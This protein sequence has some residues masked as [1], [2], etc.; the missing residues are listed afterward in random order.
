MG[1]ASAALTLAVL[2]AAAPAHAESCTGTSSGG[3]RFA[4]CFDLGNRLSLTAATDGFGG[5]IAVRH[6]ITFEDD[7]DLVWKMSH[8]FFDASYSPFGDR[9]YGTLYRGTF[10]RHSRDG[11]IVL[12]LGASLQKVFLPFDVG[13]LF[14][15]GRVE[16]HTP[17]QARLGIVETAALIDLARSRDSKRFVAFGPVASWDAELTRMPLAISDH[18]VA[19]F[20]SLLGEIH[21][22]G[23]T[24]RTAADLRGEL[25]M[26]WHSTRG[27]VPSGRAVAWLERV[28]LAVNDRPIALYAQFRY[29]SAASEA[30]AG[31]G[32]RIVLFDRTDP[33]VSLDPPR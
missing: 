11:H 21:I 30:V 22:E 31:L 18:A 23:S 29:E 6:D 19:P 20:T 33:R 7:P 28:V 1:T 26:V 3:S 24:G 2:A 8:Q 14:E 32:V 15:I 25:G 27:W 10:L 16:W 13:A 12:P 5:A 17:M 4:A 9:F